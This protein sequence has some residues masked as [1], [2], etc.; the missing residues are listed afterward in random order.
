MHYAAQHE[1]SKTTVMKFIRFY[2]ARSN[3]KLFTRQ[4][5]QKKLKLKIKIKKEEEKLLK[6]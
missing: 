4:T 5:Q 1:T 6:K 2:Y 3:K